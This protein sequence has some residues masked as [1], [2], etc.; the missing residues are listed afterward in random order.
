MNSPK[1][2]Q[3]EACLVAVSKYYHTDPVKVLTSF[4]ANGAATRKARCLLWYHMHDCGMSYHQIG[5]IFG[6]LSIDHVTKRAKQG[7]M[8][9]NEED[10]MLLKTLP[11]IETTLD[12]ANL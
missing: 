11:R 1:A 5:R 8:S 6:N 7:M 3:I 12:I 9:M 2:Q 10:R 4:C